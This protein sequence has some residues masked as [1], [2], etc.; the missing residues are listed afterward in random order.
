MQEHPTDFTTFRSC[1]SVLPVYLKSDMVLREVRTHVWKNQSVDQSTAQPVKLSIIR[2]GSTHAL[3]YHSLRTACYCY[4]N[5]CRDCDY[6]HSHCFL[7]LHLAALHGNFPCNVLTNHRGSRNKPQNL[8]LD[9]WG[10]TQC[11]F[12]PRLLPPQYFD[13]PLPQISVILLFPYSLA[14]S[15]SPCNA[16]TR[17]KP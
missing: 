10:L 13:V 12:H 16:H 2:K 5:Y 4:L 17:A 14:F 9:L 1:K 15:L 6:C 8:F 7:M 11:R 3:T